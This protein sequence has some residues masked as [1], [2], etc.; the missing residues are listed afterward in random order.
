MILL[1]PLSWS[2][3]FALEQRSV[4]SSATA[5]GKNGFLEKNVKINGSTAFNE[6]RVHSVHSCVQEDLFCSFDALHK[7]QF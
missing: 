6:A 1:L 4:T 3:L 5:W 7:R 2:Q